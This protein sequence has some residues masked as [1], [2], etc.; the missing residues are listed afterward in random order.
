[1]NSDRGEVPAN[2]LLCSIGGRVAHIPAESFAGWCSMCRSSICLPPTIQLTDGGKCGSGE[3]TL[4]RSSFMLNARKPQSRV[5]SPIN[6]MR[7][8]RTDKKHV[9]P[10]TPDPPPSLDKPVGL[11][12]WCA[13]K[14]DRAQRRLRP[15][16][17]CSRSWILAQIHAGSAIRT[18]QSLSLLGSLRGS[19]AH[20]ARWFFRDRHRKHSSRIDVQDGAEG[21]W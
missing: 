1:M 9:N 3:F 16:A 19:G 21:L 2:G 15:D 4:S 14:S 8:L 5:L 20:H 7:K 13:G 18:L 6:L 17:A 12:G 11:L 10:G